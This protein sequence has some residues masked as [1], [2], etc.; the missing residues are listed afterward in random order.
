[1]TA[2]E[3]TLPIR[4]V[5]VERPPRILVI[6]DDRHVRMLLRDL[7]ATWGYDADF[8]ADGVEGLAVFRRGRY[9]AVLTDLAMEEVTGLEVAD[10][11]HRRDPT[12]AVIL[13]TASRDEVGGEDAPPG[14]TVLRKPL[15]IDGLR[16]SL[17]DTLHRP[18]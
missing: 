6:E 15:E 3:R 17:R 13:F 14:L 2:R 5:A 10:V 4:D 1:M 7:L 18:A 9:D 8:A 11:V 16:R 12:V